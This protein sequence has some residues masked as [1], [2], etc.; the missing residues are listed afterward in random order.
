MKLEETC[1]GKD[2]LKYQSP[3]IDLSKGVYKNFPED[4]LVK[5]RKTQ[6]QAQKRFDFLSQF[7]HFSEVSQYIFDDWDELLG[8]VYDKHLTVKL[9]ASY[10]IFHEVRHADRL[11]GYVINNTDE[12]MYKARLIIDSRYSLE[13]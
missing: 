10:A 9:R 3:G 8:V 2:I 13:R 4:L 11:V 7:A 1:S 6:K 5:M 12:E